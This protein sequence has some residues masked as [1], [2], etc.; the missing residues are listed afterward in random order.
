MSKGDRLRTYIGVLTQQV[1]S[2]L[3]SQDMLFDTIDHIEIEA[4]KLMK[5]RKEIEQELTEIEEQEDE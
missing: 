4:L 2:C 3:Q 5:L 1:D